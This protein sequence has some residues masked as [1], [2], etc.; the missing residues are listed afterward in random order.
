MTG[1]Y[2]T[3]LPFEFMR[4]V[5]DFDPEW[6]GSYFI[7]RATV[8]P[9]VALLVQVWPQL[10]KWKEAHSGASSSDLGVEQNLAAGAF[11][12]LLEWLREV[13]L[14]DAVFLRQSYPNHPIFQ[15]PVFSC[16]EF[17]AFAG[18][19]RESCR[20][21]QQDSH[22]TAIQ[23][24]IPVVAEQLRTVLAQQSAAGQLA[25]RH[26]DLLANVDA[27]MDEFLRT[28]YTITIGP[29][30]RTCASHQQRHSVARETVAT[31][32]TAGAIH[33]PPS[34]EQE[35]MSVGAAQG[36]VQNEPP[37]P[38]SFKLPRSV[39]SVQELLRLWRQGWDGMPSV[40]SLECDWGARWRQSTEKNYF[41]TRKVI[42]DE[43]RRRAQS[44]AL[45]EDIVARQMDEERGS[46]SLDKLFKAIREEKKGGRGRQICGSA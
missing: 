17:E 1:C 44:K 20:Q 10:D 13:L 19:V 31:L 25:E 18:K 12:E 27:K 32:Q 7:P 16:T 30:S 21:A 28:T 43:V 37:K 45:A 15:D 46:D 14:Q 2:L 36:R 38:P 22:T 29:G 24:A 33:T 39:K 11:L 26:M 34:P 42:V 41:S 9:P 8:R 4:A 5:A 23:K 40:D 35:R 6:S 3:S